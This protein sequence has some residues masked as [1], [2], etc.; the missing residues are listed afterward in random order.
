MVFS[1]SLDK[2]IPSLGYVKGNIQ[3]IS[4]LANK[5]KTSATIEQLRIFS[6]NVLKMYK[7]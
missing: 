2:I 7:E 6:K 1:P 3:V 5:M 4:L